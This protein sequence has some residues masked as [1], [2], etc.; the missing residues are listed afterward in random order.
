MAYGYRIRIGAVGSQKKGMNY[1][2]LS[3]LPFPAWAVLTAGCRDLDSIYFS[4]AGG[5]PTYWSTG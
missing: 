5:Q 3:I 2:Q 1:V 4:P